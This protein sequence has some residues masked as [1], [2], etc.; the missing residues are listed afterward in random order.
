MSS[1]ITF[2]IRLSTLLLFISIHSISYVNAQS[3]LN[4]GSLDNKSA[5]ANS[6]IV[7]ENLDPFVLRGSSNDA[8]TVNN[9]GQAT[10]AD[11]GSS[12]SSSSDNDASAA[13]DGSSTSSSSDNDASAADDGSSTSSSNDDN[14]DASTSSSNDNDG[15]DKSS[16]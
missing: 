14:N 2:L 9:N 6:A 13:D 11:D 15:D 4:N 3:A 7:S 8:S 10:D 16:K 5:N 12:T 1:T